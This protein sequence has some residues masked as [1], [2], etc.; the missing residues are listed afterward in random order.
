[1][2]HLPSAPFIRV[3]LD[4]IDRDVYFDFAS[5]HFHEAGETIRKESFNYVYDAFW[6]VPLYVQRLMKDAFV[7]IP[8]GMTCDVDMVKR[9][10]EDY[11]KENDSHLRERLSFITEAKKELLVR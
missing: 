5:C 9:L 2:E 8:V 7:E 10:I 11:V 6:G 4:A 3:R 1:M